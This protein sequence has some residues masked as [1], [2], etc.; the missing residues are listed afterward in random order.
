MECDN[1]TDFRVNDIGDEKKKE[2][3]Y[4]F[5]K[6][7]TDILGALIGLILLSPIFLIVAIAIKLDSKGPIIFGHTRKGLGGKD[8]KVYKFRTMYE[9]S[10]EIFDNFTEEQKQ[11]FYKNFKLD[12]DPRITKIG[13]FLRRSSIDELPQ[14]IN[15][16]NG[17]MSI[18]GPRPIVEKEIALYGE[19]APK[20]FSVVPGLTGY[21]QANGRSDTTYQER[22]KMDMYYIDNRSLGLDLKIIFKTFSSVIKGE[23]AI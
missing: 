12:N 9:N 13:N 6:R 3:F 10:K 8:I 5:V 17:S 23:G 15:I 16:L 18:V 20:L 4:L 7:V 14:L 11:E 1:M 22:I 21:W 19:Y 2:G